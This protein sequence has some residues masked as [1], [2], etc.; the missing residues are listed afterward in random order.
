MKTKIK[1]NICFRS[2][3]VF[4]IVA[5]ARMTAA[6]TLVPLKG[7]FQGQ[8]KE[9]TRTS[10]RSSGATPGRRNCHRRCYPSWPIHNA[11]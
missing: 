8:E 1:T 5:L 3:V 6:D 9:P 2:A 10:S 11:L 7:S 4:L